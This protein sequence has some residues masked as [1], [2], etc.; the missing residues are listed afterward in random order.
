[1]GH[2]WKKPRAKPGMTNQEYWGFAYPLLKDGTIAKLVR[3]GKERRRISGME[4]NCLELQEKNRLLKRKIS[5]FYEQGEER[6][7]SRNQR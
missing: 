5:E 6:G 2:P 3:I 7:K 4:Q 1:M